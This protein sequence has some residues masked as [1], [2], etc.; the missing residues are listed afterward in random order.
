VGNGDVREILPEV[1]ETLGKLG[2]PASIDPIADLL[3]KFEGPRR[4]PWPNEGAIRRRTE[5]ALREISGAQFRKADEWKAWWRSSSE[6]MKGRARRVFWS[7][8]THERA[9]AGPAE[10]APA[11]ALLVSIRIT[12]PEEDRR[13]PKSKKKR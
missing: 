1:I 9:E 2:N 12:E 6:I 4:D 3:Q 8:K 7:R 13:A 11:D 5:E 10:K